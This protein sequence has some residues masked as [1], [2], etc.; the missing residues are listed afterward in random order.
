MDIPERYKGHEQAFVKHSLLK[1]YLERLFMIIGQFHRQIRY[2]DCFSGPWQEEGRDLKHTSIR[3]SLDLM[4]QC[5][6]KLREM[7]REVRFKAL[8]IEK[9][10]R[11]FRKLQEYLATVPPEE[12]LVEALPGDFY[13]LRQS[14]LEW[15]GPDDF[16][17]FFIDPKGWKRVVEIST[18]TPLLRRPNSEFLINFMY[19]FLIRAHTQESF[20][21]EMEAIFG[22][23][24]DTS[25]MSSTERE[26]YLVD[27][28]KMRLK[29]I[30]PTGGLS[31]PRAVTVPVLFPLK[32]RTK[33]HLVYLTR[34]AKG[35]TVFMSESEKL[36][37]VQRR[38]R[39]LA[40]RDKRFSRTRQHELFSADTMGSP[41]PQKDLDE[42]MDYWLKHLMTTPRFFGIEE[43]ALML[44]ETGW[45]ES[46]L[47]AA[48]G[49]LKREGKVQN[50]D[51][52]SQRRRTRFIHFE[53]NS[54]RGERLI[55]VEK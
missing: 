11:A 44:E 10:K 27:L 28:Y 38:V 33:Y 46:D 16:T 43:L 53:E 45:F 22:Y 1:A 47:Q 41:V 2:V 8:F 9:D 35:I 14:I 13:E 20:Q 48:F 25:G 23:A 52:R 36:G 24:P 49:A 7:G 37:L 39:A 12:V 51:D 42:V 50:M 29:E 3:I 55:R 31:K 26:E 18:L 21:A 34:S 54:N 40:K 32:N 5:R 19:D 30:L 6:D 17:F 15:C 4:R